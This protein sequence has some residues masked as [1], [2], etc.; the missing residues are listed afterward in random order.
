[1]THFS[2]E[3]NKKIVRRY[4]EKLWNHWEFNLID[5]IMAADFVFRGSLGAT[6]R[7]REE[8][9]SYMKT[10]RAAFPDFHNQ[11]EELI[12]ED[13]KV[14]ARLIYRGTHRGELFGIAP[15]NKPIEYAGVAIFKFNKGVMIEGWVLGDLI[16][17]KKQ[18][19]V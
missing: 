18:L 11:I 5:E 10:V 6:T 9:L 8:F 16:N 4:Y 3:D 14:A 1:M 12:A 17:L 15:T 13:D 19:E 7:R 2:Y